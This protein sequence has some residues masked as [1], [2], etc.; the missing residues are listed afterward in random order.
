LARSRVEPCCREHTLAAC[1]Q[2][3][4]VAHNENHLCLYVCLSFCLGVWMHTLL[5]S[6][7]PA[8][9][10]SF[11]FL[12]PAKGI[13]AAQPL[14]TKVLRLPNSGFS[15]PIGPLRPTFPALQ[16]IDLS[17][18]SFVSDRA[19]PWIAFCL[20]QQQ[21]VYSG[22][23]CKVESVRACSTIHVFFDLPWSRPPWSCFRLQT[24]ALP[25]DLMAQ[26]GQFTAVWLAFNQLTGRSAARACSML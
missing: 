11:F 17:L 13:C 12:A 7:L 6:L 15:G 18:N 5:Y 16:S 23:S 20:G 2:R 3:E 22:V 14:S 9:H 21:A 10:Y 25:P 4:L 24:G 26:P 8:S 1:I 19:A